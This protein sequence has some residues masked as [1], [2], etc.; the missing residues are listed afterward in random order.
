MV[1]LHSRTRLPVLRGQGDRDNSAAATKKKLD[2][3]E[4]KKPESDK[5]TSLAL[6]W[7]QL[8]IFAVYFLAAWAKNG[9][10][11]TSGWA[12]HKTIALD[13]FKKPNMLTEFLF[14]RPL[15]CY[16]SHW[17]TLGL[18]WV[19]PFMLFATPRTRI[20]AFVGFFG[21]QAIFAITLQLFL[22]LFPFII[23]Y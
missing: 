16:F 23:D 17:G 5:V 21:M 11:W 4:E 15:L 2:H 9:E 19:G 3:V 14:S 6:L 18:D 12:A 10:D 13:C 20:A 22:F 8:Q 1:N 7:L